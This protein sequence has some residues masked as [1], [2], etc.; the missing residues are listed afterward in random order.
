[1]SALLEHFNTFHAY[2]A[3]TIT[4]WLICG[5]A[6]GLITHSHYRDGAVLRYV[7]TIV[8]L[9]WISYEVTEFARIGDEG[10]VD[11]ANGLFAFIVGAGVTWLAHR[12]ND[13]WNHR[14]FIFWSW[15]E[16]LRKL[17]ADK[18]GR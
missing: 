18:Q 5:I 2:A 9:W 6:G 8:C 11:L 10:D 3:A 12:T 15:G 14:R 1:M 16:F 17:L 13:F 7:S 4:H